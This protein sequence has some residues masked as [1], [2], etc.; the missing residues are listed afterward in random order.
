[1]PKLI[2][3][4]IAKQHF[5]HLLEGVRT[6]GEQYEIQEEGQTVA[7]LIS[8]EDAAKGWWQRTVEIPPFAVEVPA[9]PKFGD[10]SSNVASRSPVAGFTDSMAMALPPSVVR[11]ST[12]LGASGVQPCGSSTCRTAMPAASASNASLMP[13]SGIAALWRRSTGMRPAFHRDT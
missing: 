4:S 10:V 3:A 9:D 12:G 7:V 13:P 11:P 1:M 2:K 5:E 8:L 6:Q